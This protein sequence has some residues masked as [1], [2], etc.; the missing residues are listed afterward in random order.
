MSKTQRPSSRWSDGSDDGGEDGMSEQELQKLQRQYKRLCGDRRAYT[1]D[2]QNVIRK[3]K[4]LIEKLEGENHEICTNLENTD[5]NQNKKKD[6]RVTEQL[7]DLVYVHDESEDKIQEEKEYIQELDDKIRQMEREI[8]KQ[9]K[10]MGGV[11][12]SQAAQIATQKQ[13]R[14]LENR[15]DKAMVNFNKQLTSNQDLRKEIDHLRTER[16][17]FDNIHK[18]LS[19]ELEDCKKEMA[20][21]IDQ[22]TSAYEQRDEYQNKM[23]QMQERNQK[24]QAQH[25]SEMKELER[26]ITHD[27]KLKEF[28]NIKSQDRADYKNE[29]AAKK[30]RGDGEKAI[31][32]DRQLINDYDLAFKRIREIT[33]EEDL[34]IIVKEFIQKEDKNFALFNYVNELSNDAELLQ[35]QCD[36]IREDMKK[37]NEEDIRMEGER[38][39]QLK[40]LEVQLDV[41]TKDAD[42]DE[43][44]L[45][46]I[47]KTLD[48]LRVGVQS[49]FDKINC[50]PKP[51]NELLGSGHG[52]RDNNMMI[53]L[54][55]VEQR[56]NELL[57]IQN[58]IQT[59]AYERGEE[60]INQPPKGAL[61]GISENAVHST[62]LNIMPPTTGDDLADDYSSDE[63]E[64]PFTREEIKIKVM[65]GI[66]KKEKYRYRMDPGT[67]GKSNRDKGRKK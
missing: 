29:E 16:R 14:V 4:S 23:V 40:E 66:G 42:S 58:Y 35:E 52:I 65:K 57:S 38:K 27:N 36:D 9:H 28:M 32:H 5:S 2:S 47:N 19:K 64:R 34:D 1:E 21:V 3:Q 50:D 15:L 46:E 25:D 59:R 10:R 49:L 67:P 18:K 51:V 41:A 13:I 37:F 7:E 54:G 53:Y 8:K 62:Q 39:V 45:K 61:L 60:D 44:R 43:E 30:K 6:E 31:D 22:A 17:R 26:V 33:E 63:E 48:Q 20:E 55:L 12:Q 24:D 56:T 11:H